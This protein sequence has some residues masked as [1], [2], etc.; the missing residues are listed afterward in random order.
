VLIQTLDTPSYTQYQF[1]RNG[2]LIKKLFVIFLKMIGITYLH[3]PAKLLS[4][5]AFQI[6]KV[7]EAKVLT[8]IL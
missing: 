3:R 4:A 6:H 1:I 5:L 7:P 8:F 2:W